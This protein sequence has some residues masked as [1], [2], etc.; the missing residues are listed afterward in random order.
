MAS[1][2]KNYFRHSI[3]MRKDPKVVSLISNHGKEAYF[4]WMI[5]VE[6][7]AEFAIDNGYPIDEIFIFHKRT[8]CSE[9]MV[10]PQRLGGH[11]LAI[12][13]SLLGDLVATGERVEIK[14]PKLRKYIGRYENKNDSNSPN[15]RKE[16]EIKEKEINNKPSPLSFLFHARPEI[17]K[18]LDAGNHDT[19]TVILAR[20]KSHHELAELLEKA[21]DWSQG[22][23][24]RAETWL[25]TFVDN[26]KTSGFG[27]NQSKK[28]FKPK[29]HGVASTPENPTGDPYLQEAI[30]KGLVG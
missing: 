24:L 26:K 29:G 19:H 27:S 20:N 18:W 25:L 10:T 15:K 30:D 9:L 8:I 13:S 4:H 21:F 17:Q 2:K 6:M 22:K 28:A 5:L 1:G 7:C 11:L 14:F 12:Q 16:K 3:N 23:D